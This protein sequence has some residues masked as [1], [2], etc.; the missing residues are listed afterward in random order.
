MARKPAY[1]ELEQRIEE[2]AKEN[3][4][5]K[6]DCSEYQ[7]VF[8]SSVPFCIIDK[9][10]NMIRVNDSFCSHFL[11]EKKEVVG[12]K[13]F[14]VWQGPIC[15][16][17]DC[18]LVHILDGKNSYEHE[19]DKELENGST[20]SYLIQTLPY[21]NPEGEIIGVTESFIDITDRKKAEISLRLSEERLRTVLEN[22]PVMM[23]AFDADRKIAMW[24]KECERVTAFTD[25]EIVDNVKAIELLYPEEGYRQIVA[26]KLAWP[27]NDYYS[28][29]FDVF[30][31]DGSAK[32]VAWSNISKSFPIPGCSSWV[33]GIDVTERTL[34]ER[35]LRDREKKL[36]LQSKKLEELNTALKIMLEKKDE[37]KIELE[38]NVF[39]N[40]KGL[41]F[42]ILEKLL[43]STLD[44]RQIEF[45][46]IL[47]SNLNNIISPF[48]KKLTNTHIFL[49]PTEIQVSNYIKAGKTTKE[50]A[51]L[52]HLSKRTI[53]VHRTNIRKKLKLNNSETT[54]KSYLSNRS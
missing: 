43:T 6:Y 14:N 23:M 47:K 26:D 31:K 21:R 38:E 29:E 4:S 37:T 36:V 40:V 28:W 35:T 5:L 34:N 51:V 19:V 17:P 18:P 11:V 25:S 22:M 45:I 33:V 24:N 9:N 53:D 48:S 27:V 52:M 39:N 44:H 1:A 3:S 41:M 8:N 15:N 2:L 30:C 46:N 10:Y 49:S 32:T 7:Q 20:I 16:T 50:I 54:L 13:C 12:R 42:P